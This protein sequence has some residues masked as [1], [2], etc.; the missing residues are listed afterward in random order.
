M[1]IITL[2]VGKLVIPAAIFLI[3]L[4]G[5]GSY[6]VD[7]N[8]VFVAAVAAAFGTLYVSFRWNIGG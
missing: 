6:G 3:V 7:H 8:I 2:L 1:S 4:T 5:G